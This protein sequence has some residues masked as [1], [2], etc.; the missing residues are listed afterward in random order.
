MTAKDLLKRVHATYQP[1]SFAVFENVADAGSVYHSRFADAVAMG[2]WQSR[3]FF[4]HGFEIK[5]SRS[6]WL[7]ELKKPEKADAV[8]RFC[9]HWWVVASDESIVSREEL[10]PTWGLLVPKEKNGGLKAAVKAPKLDPQ[11]PTRLFLASI[12]RRA[13]EQTPEEKAV[14]EAYERGKKDGREERNRNAEYRELQHQELSKGVFE[15]ENASGVSLSHWNGGNVGQAVRMVL[16]GKHVTQANGIQKLKKFCEGIVK[17]CDEQLG[18]EGDL[19]E[20]IPE[21]SV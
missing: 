1:P 2:L 20:A 17:E 16:S 11:P 14:A 9:D 12:L 10:P 21:R 5:V 19:E 8:C 3:G 13:Y 6:D 15:F 4:L 7:R 18:G